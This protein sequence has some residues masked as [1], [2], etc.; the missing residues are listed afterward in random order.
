MTEKNSDLKKPM[1]LLDG[2]YPPIPTPYGEKGEIA[3]EALQQNLMFLDQFELRGFVVLGSN[4]E[5]VMLSESEKLSV[6]EAA[7][8]VIPSHRLLIAGT[9]CQSTGETLDLTK[10]AA[11]IGVDAVLII[12]PSYYR[13][14]MTPEAL[15]HHFFAI[16]DESPVPILIYNM[17]AC[18]GIDLEA[19]TVAALAHHPNI[20]GLK[21][22]SGN[23]VKMGAIRQQTGSGF[24]ILAGS[25]GFLVPAMSVGAIG[26][27][28]ALANIAPHACVALRRYFLETRQTE[29]RE[30]QLR[31]IPVN[32]AVTSRWGVPGLKAAMDILG[33]YGGPVRMPLRPLTDEMRKQLNS[34]LVNAGLKS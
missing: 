17:P 10:K 1:L 26:G 16:A 2:I 9:G 20:I 5:Y 27:I 6:I 32:D 8:E 12:T 7:R 33:L 14:L 22:S 23:I 28:M 3:L 19:E 34:L 11:R 31:M 29:A 15:M 24:Q 21:D 18:T 13:Q 30:L 25:G 4:G